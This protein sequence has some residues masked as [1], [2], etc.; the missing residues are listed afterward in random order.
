M[1]FIKIKNISFKER[2]ELVVKIPALPAEHVSLSDE[3][4]EWRG[5]KKVHLKVWWHKYHP[6]ICNHSGILHEKAIW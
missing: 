3:T 4:D 2:S 1:S 6:W 5:K